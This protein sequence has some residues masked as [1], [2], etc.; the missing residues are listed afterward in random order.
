V[1]VSEEVRDGV[2]WARLDVSDPGPGIPD[3]DLERIF[4]PFF[5]T[6]PSDTG[7]GL[8]VVK[9]FVEA[10]KGAVRVRS[11]PGKGSTFTI[12]LPLEGT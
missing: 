7:L 10:H 6:K 1:R 11:A 9:R 3:M 4:E 12:V 5:T 8:A 2:A